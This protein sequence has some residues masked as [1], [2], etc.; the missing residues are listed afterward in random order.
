MTKMQDIMLGTSH[1]FQ[2]LDTIIEFIFIDMVN[3]FRTCKWSAKVSFHDQS[4]L[5]LPTSTT[6]TNDPITTQSNSSLTGA[7]MAFTAKKITTPNAAYDLIAFFKW[8]TTNF[9]YIHNSII[10]KCNSNRK[11]FTLINSYSLDF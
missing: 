10:S 6:E 1:K 5:K 4:M 7:K 11:C 2:I 3:Y 9:T 8:I